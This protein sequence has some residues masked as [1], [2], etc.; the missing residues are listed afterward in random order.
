MWGQELHSQAPGMQFTYFNNE[1][2][3]PR[4]DI[5]VWWKLIGGKVTDF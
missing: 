5:E 3:S 1:D 4:S 2:S